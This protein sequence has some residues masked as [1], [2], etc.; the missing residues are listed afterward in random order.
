MKSG[1]YKV[2]IFLLSFYQ[3]VFSQTE[4]STDLWLPLS[5]SVSQNYWWGGMLGDSAK[6][7][8]RNY[9][10]LKMDVA[11]VLGGKTSSFFGGLRLG[12]SHISGKYSEEKIISKIAKK[13][14]TITSSKPI[15]FNN[16]LIGLGGYDNAA[17]KWSFT[18]YH[19]DL[20]FGKA[21]Y[22]DVSKTS[23]MIRL[24]LFFVKSEYF[25]VQVDNTFVGGFGGESYFLSGIG[26]N[27]N[28][29]A[30][31]P[32][33]YVVKQAKLKK[34]EEQRLVTEKAEK[35]RL[36]AKSLADQ[37][38]EDERIRQKL[39][40]AQNAEIERRKKEEERQERERFAS[41]RAEKERI[42]REGVPNLVTSFTFSDQESFLQNNIIDAGENAELIVTVHN[43]RLNKTGTGY[44]VRLKIESDNSSINFIKEHAVGDIKPDDSKV[45]KIP[46]KV[47]I[48]IKGDDATF[49][50]NTL[51]K[52][53]PAQPKSIQIPIAKLE[54][55]QLAITNVDL[56]DAGGH[57]IGNGNGIAE[58]GE[59]IEL[60]ALVKNEGVGRAL[61]ANLELISVPSGIE[62]IASIERL[63]DIGV[64]KIVKGKVVIS[65]PRTYTSSKLEYKIKVSEIRG[66]G[67]G[68]FS[69]SIDVKKQEA[70]LVFN[71]V[72]PT[73]TLTNN[74]SVSIQIIPQ[75]EG[76]L[77]AK[78]VFLK[79]S[80]RNPKVELLN[81]KVPIGTINPG[82]NASPYSITISLPRIFSE[83]SI[84]LD[85][86]LTQDDFQPYRESKTLPVI[87]L[88]PELKVITQERRTIQ[89]GERGTLEISVT[90]TGSLAAEDVTLTV[91][92][93]KLVIDDKTKTFGKLSI[94][95]TSE[96][97]RLPFT[98]TRRVPPGPLSIFIEIKERDFPMS[99]LTLNYEVIEEA[100]AVTVIEGEKKQEKPVIVQT[101][102]GKPVISITFPKDGQTLTSL[103]IVFRG[104][105][106]SGRGIQY[107]SATLNG[108]RFYYSRDDPSAQ[109]KLTA[110]EG[111]LLDFERDIPE[112]KTGQ[113]E[114]EVTVYDKENEFTVRKLSFNYLREEK[115]T[116][117]TFDQTVD[118][119]TN[120][121]ELK[122]VNPD[123]IAIVLGIEKYRDIIDKASYAKEDVAVFREYAI[124]ILGIPDDK[125]NLYFKVD[126]EVTKAEFEK[127]FTGDSWISRRVKPNSDVYIYYAGHGASHDKTPYIIP[128]DGD[129]NYPSQTGFSLDRL[130]E[131][132]SELN[133]KS[134]TVFID[135]CF[136][137]TTRENKMLLAD[138]RHGM[139]VVNNPALR[140]GKITVFTGSTGNQISSSYPEKKHG[141]FTYYLLKGIRGG[142]D[143]NGD[144]SL[145]VEELENYIVSNV[146]N[147]AGLL[148]REQTP[149]VH[150]KDKQRII[151]KY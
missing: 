66:V 27:L 65:I 59:T 32:I 41:E 55:P 137:G 83:N 126:E 92:T 56:N 80:S 134:I 48:E 23:Y 114:I 37:K 100:A 74:S 25:Q 3:F 118:V 128:Y 70:A 69:K 76:K 96:L 51:E 142:A 147:T 9:H 108:A 63:G 129:P 11:L 17:S 49:T 123:A 40:A 77:T 4:Q 15:Q 132:L 149:Q 84:T 110:T 104:S 64:G 47:G 109:A 54:K 116:L 124:K 112:T 30:L 50:I 61:N 26:I 22:G 34:I 95:T 121:P 120:I 103:P 138:A 85:I 93:D 16:F 53:N 52:M 151:V 38:A 6:F 45:I 115:I 94:G 130:Y 135:A 102:G 14:S 28:L 111:Q 82:E 119:N 101:V 81:N 19:L 87:L 71:Y 97:W 60:I 1:R 99:S 143:N 106:S 5:A 21:R 44:D 79:V 36:E 150:S 72:A 24:A 127:L 145:T 10:P 88:K 29:P 139:I 117:I 39:L 78:N 89:Q 113:N 35:E 133:V 141:L 46:L 140:S 107:I 67:T 148:D 58:T 90:N 57:A 105:A 125:N 136:S 12:F 33:E 75:N 144:K 62:K 43:K 13:E 20:G 146:K 122:F 18:G 31:Y 91:K 73:K 7:K 98:L 68:E 42:E 2:L 8:D 86:E 131:E